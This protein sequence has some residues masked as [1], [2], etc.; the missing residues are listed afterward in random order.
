VCERDVYVTAREREPIGA[1]TASQ[2]VGTE[3]CAAVLIN[4]LKPR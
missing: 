3:S 1:H 4:D 2:A